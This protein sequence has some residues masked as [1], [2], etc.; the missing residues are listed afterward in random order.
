VSRRRLFCRSVLAWLAATLS[1]VVTIGSAAPPAIAI[2]PSSACTY[3]YDAAS[4]SSEST[5]V[6]DAR[7]TAASASTSTSP[8]PSAGDL[9]ALQPV[10]VAADEGAG[11]LSTAYHYTGAQNV[12]SIESNGLRA[13]AYATPNGE[14][15]PLQA[16]IDLALPPNRGLPGRPSASISTA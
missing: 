13:G 15:S 14:L 16:Q 7:N 12:A 5:F 11:G 1:L 4:N 10:F 6:A 3:V 2:T 8:A 9:S